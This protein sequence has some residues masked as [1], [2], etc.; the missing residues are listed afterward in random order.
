MVHTSTDSVAVVVPNWNG[1]NE[2]KDCLDSLLHQ[3]QTAEII[4]VDNGSTD[5][6]VE[7]IE[8]DYPSVTLLK[9]PKNRGFAGGVNMGIRYALEKNMR[10]I[11]LFNNDAIAE[12]MWLEKLLKTLEKNQKIGIA[13][14]KLVSSDKTHIDTTG[15]AYTLWGL[16]FPRGRGEKTLDAYDEETNVFGATGGASLYRAS[17]FEDIGLFDEKFFAYYEDIDISFRAQ[18]R[19]WQIQYE[20]SAIAYHKIGATSGKIPGFTTYQ[21]MKNLPMLFW[22]NTPLS[23]TPRMFPRLFFAYWTMMARAMVDGRAW[24]ALKGH[25]VFLKNLWHIYR[26][27][28]RIQSKKTASAD[29]IWSIL[30]HDLPPNAHNLRKIRS[31]WWRVVRKT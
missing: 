30:I 4:V 11:A 8:T 25:T 27:R 18:L 26:E 15:E 10:Y 21:T 2:L 19:G 17:L 9:E 13:T 20:P 31:L 22:K 7:C 12:K 5:G 1:K 28:R 16:P 24:P 23:L 6:S 14:S 3:T 29:Y